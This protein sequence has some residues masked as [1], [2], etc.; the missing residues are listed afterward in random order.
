M[1]Q[2]GISAAFMSAFVMDE[3]IQAILLLGA[4]N[5]RQEMSFVNLFNRI[6]GHDFE[7]HQY[8]EEEENLFR[9][10]LDANITNVQTSFDVAAGEGNNFAIGYVLLVNDEQMLVTNVVG[11]TLTVVR[12]HAGTTAVAHTAGDV[13]EALGMASPEGVV[14]TS[15]KRSPR[16]LVENYF[17]EFTE[18][19]NVT[20]RAT[21]KRHKDYDEMLAEERERAVWKQM[22]LLDRALINNTGVFDPTDGQHVTKGFRNFVAE[23]NGIQQAT[24]GYAN[25]AF[26]AADLTALYVELNQ[27]MS[28]VNVIVCNVA[29]KN[30]LVDLA[31]A[32]GNYTSNINQG[33]IGA[34]AGVYYDGIVT[35][36]WDGR[37]LPFV[38]NKHVPDGAAIFADSTSLGM[39]VAPDMD[40]ADLFL[41]VSPEPKN[42]ALMQETLRTEISVEVQRADKQAYLANMFT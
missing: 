7:K 36:G 35:S 26:G 15:F 30:K 41:Q 13:V 28:N 31:K 33:D 14:N 6:D 42:S 1:A 29:T 40:G 21:R 9:S 12:G 25:G 22:R 23:R 8:Y 32:E 19:V 39:I 2:L 34:N 17:Q 10:T 3:D 27:R 24:L 20:K 18:D 38:I 4:D 16:T 11:D 5:Y 37:V